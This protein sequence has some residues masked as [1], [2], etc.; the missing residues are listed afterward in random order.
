MKRVKENSLDSRMKQYEASTDIQL[1]PKMPIVIR[2]DGKAFHTYTKGMVKPFDDVL[3]YAMRETTRALCKEVHT[4]VFGYT[5]SDEITLI[6]KLPSRITSEE[7]FGARLEKIVSVTASKATKHFNK[8]FTQKVNELKASG[9]EIDESLMENYIKKAGDAEFDCRAFNMPEWDCINNII[10]R[11]NDAMRNSVEMVG[12]ANF[13]SKELYKVNVAGIKEKLLNEKGIDWETAFDSYQKYG[14][15]CYKVSYTKE[16]DGEEVKRTEW[17]I[18]TENNKIIKENR[19]WFKQ[20]THL[21][22]D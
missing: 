12:H 9:E 16:V 1:V 22:E 5:Q 17:H 4:C 11:Q 6:L 13:S 8:F 19:D 14:A 3:G 15:S 20:V 7:Y 21:S 18:D 2:I 10:W